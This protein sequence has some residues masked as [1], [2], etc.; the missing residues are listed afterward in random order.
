MGTFL[1]KRKKT[2]HMGFKGNLTLNVPS[3]LMGNM[4]D[5]YNPLKRKPAIVTTVKYV[6]HVCLDYLMI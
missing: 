6:V 3:K 4:S 2:T 5:W 1:K